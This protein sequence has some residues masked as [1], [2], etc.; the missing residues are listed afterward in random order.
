MAVKTSWN[1]GDVLTAADL[2]D[3]FAV[4]APLA[5]PTFTGTVTIPDVTLGAWTSYTPTWT[6]ITQGN[7]TSTGAYA[8]I[9][10]T[11]HFWAKF[12]YGSTSVMGTTTVTPSLP[13]TKATNCPLLLI[14][15]AND[16][17]T[18]AFP[19]F[20]IGNDGTLHLINAST[21]Y[22]QAATFS[23]TAPFTWTTG[24]YINVN[25]TYEAA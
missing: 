15:V 16:A 3:T 24:D 4:K 1:A 7:G 17:G 14:A 10:K 25:G 22:A 19:L 18:G 8:R 6:G 21:T 5:S 23:T 20:T 12:V 11:I 13:V 9:G 2:T